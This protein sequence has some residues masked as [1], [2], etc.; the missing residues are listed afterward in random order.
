MKPNFELRVLVGIS[1]LSLL[2]VSLVDAANMTT[3]NPGV[4]LSTWVVTNSFPATN[5]IT[6][7]EFLSEVAAANLDYAAQR[8]NVD[9][10]KAAVA[11][12]KEFPN[13]TLS[14]SGN[15]DMRF[16]GV[17]RQNQ[18]GRLVEQTEPEGR[19]IG[20]DQTIE[21]FGKRKWRRS[22]ADQA[23]RAAAATLDE[24]FCSLRGDA[25]KGYVEALATQRTLEQQR[26]A[27]D[28]LSQLVIAQGHRLNAGDIGE[29]DFTQS[30]VDEL[31]SQNDLLNAENDA[32]TAQLALN[33]FL[34]RNRG[35]TTFLFRGK[36][37]LEPRTFNPSQLIAAALR[38][39]PD[40]IALRHV[41]DTAT[42]GIH[43]AKA[44]RVPDVDIGLNYL[45]N[46]ATENIVNPTE[47]DYW[48]T[49]SFSLP[50]PLWHGQRAEIQTAQ[51]TA[52][53]AEKT[54]QSAELKAEV[55][56]RQTFYTYQIMQ[57]R[58]QKFQGELLKGA[59]DV[60]TAKR[61]SYEHGQTTLL[62][63]LD[64]QRADNDIHQSYNDALADAAKALIELERAAELWDIEF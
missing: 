64:A 27:A 59:D 51:F 63:L 50:L 4:P 5:E 52:A 44:N 13:P 14:L 21:Y 16:H 7:H 48:L 1:S 57:E 45:Y 26:K 42:S 40:L 23:Y 15:R 53:Q 24:F 22:V 29:T 37:E 49:L 12:A 2:L 38:N 11:I 9:I 56:V 30:R 60:L 43:L 36:L 8:Y 41:R 19:S 35:Q 34:G 6:F 31:R 55:Q 47:H 33:A 20:I 3:N 32:R 10:A 17:Y 39:R 54:L 61:F 18:D 28:Y 46:T 58:V 62:D 25:S